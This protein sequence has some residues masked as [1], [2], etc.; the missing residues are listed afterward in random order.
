MQKAK[1]I[2]KSMVKVTVI[3][4]TLLASTALMGCQQGAMDEPRAER[5]TPATV[6]EPIDPQTNPI[7]ASKARKQQ[8]AIDTDLTALK[9]DVLA[10]IADTSAD[11][12]QQCR[13]IGFGAKPC[14]GPARYIAASVKNIDEDDLMAKVAAYNAA[15]A[16]N[17]NKLGL[18]SDC[19]VVPKPNVVLDQGVCRLDDTASGQT[20]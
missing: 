1:Q 15:S 12:I 14:G 10:L 6:V 8:M 7:A 17:N 4:A 5:L 13:V 16:E 11:N 19:A 20:Y 18:M 2:P 9:Q 3:L